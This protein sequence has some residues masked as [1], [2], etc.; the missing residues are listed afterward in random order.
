MSP[1]FHLPAQKSTD[2]HG[3]SAFFILTTEKYPITPICGKADKYVTC[4]IVTSKA[5]LH[6]V[7]LQMHLSLTVN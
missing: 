7:A 4:A 5:D 2:V 6:E 3:Y 1:G